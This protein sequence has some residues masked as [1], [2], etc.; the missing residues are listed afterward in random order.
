MMHYLLD[1]DTVSQLIRG[2]NIKLLAKAKGLKAQ[3]A[4]ISVI[5]RGELAF[6]VA[7]KPMSDAF[8]RNFDAVLSALPV[9]T[10]PEEVSKH[11][12]DIR[13]HL[14]KLGQPI[15]PN[16]MWIAAHARALGYTLVS[17]NLREFGRV[18]KLRVESWI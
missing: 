11:Y 12:G 7:L 16:D 18:P 4:A 2:H 10:V 8:M 1:T 13:A 3:Q 17:H 9:L 15:G 14:H 5:S 6:G